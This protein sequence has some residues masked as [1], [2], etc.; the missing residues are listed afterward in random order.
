MQFVIDIGL[1]LLYFVFFLLLC[2]WMWRFWMA[3]VNQ[4]HLNGLDWLMLEVKLPREIS[5]SPYAT[6]LALSSLLQTGGLSHRYGKLFK[7]N[8]PIFSSLEIASIEGVIH[9]YIRIQ[10]KFRPLVESNFY[11]QY[12]GVELVE[13][14]D[15]TKNIQYHHLTKDV[16]CW[17]AT[18]SLSKKWKPKNPHTGKPFSKSSHDEKALPKNDDDEFS[19][20]ADF[21]PIKTYVDYGLDKDPK[22]EYRI[23]PLAQLLEVMGSLG[24]GEHFWYQ[25]II[26]D[27]SNFNG[28]KWPKFFVD[29]K[30][31]HKSLA[32]IAADKKKEIRT[33]G[34]SVKGNAVVDE[35]GVPKIIEVFNKDLE[36]QFR[37]EEKDGKKIKVPIKAVARH[38]E[39]KAIAKKEQDLTVDEKEELELINK[40]LAKSTVLGTVRAL[41][42]TKNESFNTAHI[43][44]ILSLPKPFN[45]YNTFAP[46][47]TDPYDFPWQNIG[48]RRVAW[49]TEE[50]FE[51]YVEREAFFPH[52]GSRDGLDLWSDTFF[53][54][55][56]M[57]TRKLFRMIY[58]MI[59]HPFDHPSMEGVSVYNLE[60][61]ATLWHLPGINVTTPTLP[62][63]DSTKGVAPVNLPV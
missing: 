8:M 60:E 15:Y 62:R 34:W 51:E 53:W 43:Q 57:K 32:E 50:M 29:W 23:D 5:K 27:E 20:K 55:S 49:R 40:K 39:T 3:Y 63:I 2:A 14:E 35:F 58:E 48:G 31:N 45:G 30:H 18:Y 16:S 1:L 11:A 21:Y 24:K 56:S 28:T 9:F 46:K 59:L 12:P 37:E 25:V 52:I 10:R 33:S 13:A 17:G 22:D 47:V 36:Q 7:G 6:E 38:L 4:K 19:Y 41:Y 61:I 44:S 54:T 42:V 26:S